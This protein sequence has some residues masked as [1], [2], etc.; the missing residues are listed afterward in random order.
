VCHID[1]FDDTKLAGLHEPI[2]RVHT[3]T[4][5]IFFEPKNIRGNGEIQALAVIYYRY[6]QQVIQLIFDILY[7]D[8]KLKFEVIYR[9]N[10]PY[11]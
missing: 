2:Y 7:R 10:H 1:Q 8:S 11:T 6:V 3:D 9:P 4:V 5:K